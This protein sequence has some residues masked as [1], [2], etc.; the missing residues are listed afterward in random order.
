MKTIKGKVLFVAMPAFNHEISDQKCH[1]LNLSKPE[2]ENI[3]KLRRNSEW[4][5]LNYATEEQ[6]GLLVW[7]MDGIGFYEYLPKDQIRPASL[8]WQ[9]RLK[10]AKESLFSLLKA[11]GCKTKEM[12]DNLYDEV[13]NTPDDYLLII[14]Q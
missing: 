9:F 12:C 8:N 7:E 4:F 6:C 3:D 10:T 2:A 5:Y 13:E 11:N 14:K 1:R